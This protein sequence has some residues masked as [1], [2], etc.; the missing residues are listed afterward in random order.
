MQ[1][2]GPARDVRAALVAAPLLLGAFFPWAYGPLHV[3]AYAAGLVVLMR[4]ARARAAGAE[5][6]P[7]PA[8]APLL[9]FAAIVVLQLLPLPPPLLRLV[10]PGTYAFHS[11]QMLVPLTAWKPVTVSP[12]DTFFGLVYFGGAAMLYLAVFRAFAGERW[13]RWLMRA[14]VYV[15]MFMTLV[16]LAQKASGTEKPYGIYEAQD[17][18]AVFGPYL[19]RNH[20]AGYLVMAIPL[21]L[22]L[23]MEAL[24]DLQRAWGRRRVGWLALGD[25]V[26]S[27]FVRRAAEAMV[28]VV[29][30][31]AAASRGAFIGFAFSL[32]V[33]AAFARRRLLLL[34]IGVV[35]FV[36][37]SWIGLDAIVQGFGTRGLEGSRFGLWRDALRMFPDFPLLGVGWNAFGMAYLRYQTFWRYYFFQAAHNEYLDLLLTTGVIGTAVAFWGL[38]RLLPRAVARALRSPLDAGLLASLLGLA[39]HNLVDFNWQIQAN[40]ATFAALLALAVRPLDRAVAGP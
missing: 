24:V 13:R 27:A 9:A 3:V 31:V 7:L 36:G 19:S 40:A 4:G 5:P 30:L 17:A 39:C 33:I 1:A 25:P 34:A 28:L 21:A 11:E 6:S 14:V 32:L 18:W 15:G 2:D 38:V 20:F 12:P 23:T 8:A 37:V 35:A 22:G 26:G 10:S 29:G 16:A